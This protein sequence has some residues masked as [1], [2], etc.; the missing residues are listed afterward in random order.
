M[1]VALAVAFVVALKLH[2]GRQSRR[3]GRGAGPRRPAWPAPPDAGTFAGRD[4]AASPRLR[5]R[6]SRRC[7]SLARRRRPAAGATPQ[8]EQRRRSTWPRSTC[9][10]RAART[11]TTRPATP[12]PSS[13]SRPAS[14][15]CSATP[16]VTLHPRRRAT[17]RRWTTVQESADRHRHRRAPPTASTSNLEGTA[18][19]DTCV[20]AK[21][22]EKLVEEGK[23]PAVTYAHI[24]REPD[25]SG[26]VLQYWFFWYFNQ[27][28]D[29]HEGDWEG[30]Q[31]S[32][33]A[34]T[35]T[36]ARWTKNRAK[37]SSSST[38][39]ASAPAGKTRKVQKEG[40]HPIVYPAAGSHATFYDSA[41]YVEN[42]Q[43]GSGVGCDNT[44]EPL[45]ELRPTA[46]SDA[47]RRRRKAA[48]SPGSPTT[49]AG[50]NGKRASTTARPGRRRRRSGS[51]PF[52]WMA[53]A[54]DDQPAA[55]RRLDRRPAGHRGLLR[56]RRRG[57]GL[58]Q[59]RRRSRRPP[60]SRRWS[61]SRLL[62]VL[63]VGLT[64]WRP[65]RP[66]HSC[67]RRAPSASWSAPPASSTAATGRSWSRSRWPALVIVGGD[68]PA[69]Q[70]ARRTAAQPT[71]QPGAPA[72]TWRSPTCSNRSSRPIAQALVAAIV[73][74]FVRL[75]K[76][77][78]ETAGF[79]ACWRGM[80]QRFWRVVGAQLLATLGDAAAGD[81][82]DRHP[83]RGLEAGRLGL[84]QAGSAVH[85]QALRE[86]FRGSS[87]LV[88]GRW[89][90]AVRVS[91]SSYVLLFV[92]GPVFTFALIF[93]PLPLLGSTCS[94]R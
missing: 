39:A 89:W 13:T 28:N 69:R 55:A 4:A 37:S 58:H 8:P 14:T 80:R 94:A 78:A 7:C 61:A 76:R 64:R 47:G 15:P 18:L 21:A 22:F 2:A 43:H 74:I 66:R 93:T 46:G 3:A 45:R 33:E 84:R 90:H 83:L 49:A 16:T 63:F 17:G 38:P 75:L 70:P 87:E 82:R 59:P 9:R 19:G 51:E 34:E 26:F 67:G 42:G 56:R 24:A 32:F 20:Y 54:A 52:A 1:A 73:V 35:T 30:M 57:L 92:T 27:F 91:S 6:R 88:R 36:A 79:R 23:A 65:G 31:L 12:R 86:S 50:A 5:S 29:L 10:S 71:R 44:T 41:V 85:R 60:R 77:T 25:H 62:I 81:H 68:Q 11:D 40:T 48:R 72:S 53:E